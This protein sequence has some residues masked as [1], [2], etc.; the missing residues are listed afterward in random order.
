M[1][2]AG[3]GSNR[4][5]IV[6]QNGLILVRAGTSPFAVTT[7]GNFG[8]TG[9]NLISTGGERG[10]LSMAFHPDYNGTTNLFFYI[11]YTE[12]T[13]GR[14]MVDRFETTTTDPVTVNGTTRL[15]IM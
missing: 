6:Q 12:I 2:N 4:L 11:Y 8:P 15:N 10:L 7:F 9:L 13:S 5:F 3:D 14:I 1:V